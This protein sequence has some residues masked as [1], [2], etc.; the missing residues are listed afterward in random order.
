MRPKTV[1][2]QCQSG[3]EVFSDAHLNHHPVVV[4]F[5]CLPPLYITAV[6]QIDVDGIE[7]ELKSGV[8][9]QP[10]V[11]GPCKSAH[12]SHASKTQAP[13]PISV[14]APFKCGF[15][16]VQWSGLPSAHRGA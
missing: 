11:S 9:A 5:F 3:A 7:A 15:S 4:G 13:S 14:Q 8:N 1:G 12:A 16:L 2:M 10:K 6:D